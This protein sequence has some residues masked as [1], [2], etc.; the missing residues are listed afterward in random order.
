MLLVLLRPYRRLLTFLGEIAFTLHIYL[1]P[2]ISF[3]FFFHSFQL[4]LTTIFQ[5]HVNQNILQSIKKLYQPLLLLDIL[6]WRLPS[7]CSI[8]LTLIVIFW[9][10]FCCGSNS[11]LWVYFSKQYWYF[12]LLWTKSQSFIFQNFKLGIGKFDLKKQ[13]DHIWALTGMWMFQ[14]LMGTLLNWLMGISKPLGH[15][16]WR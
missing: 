16:F 2:I 13:C 5:K 7:Y 12:R 4:K 9:V 3:F 11:C 6:Y 14:Q 15:H 1:L 10:L 8:E